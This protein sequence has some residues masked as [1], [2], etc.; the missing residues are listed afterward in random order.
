MKKKYRLNIEMLDS[1]SATE[2][3][4]IIGEIADSQGI[5]WALCGGVAMQI[6]GS[7]R[8]TKDLDFIASGVMPLAPVKHLSFGGHRYQ[9]ET[10]RQIVDADWIV[11]R[12]AWKDLFKAAL[13]DA[14]DI[15][16]VPVV[17]PEW[18]VLLKWAA[19]RP[20]D[21]EDA[22]FLLQ[23]GLVNRRK[24]KANY[25]KVRGH[26]EWT[27]IFTGLSRWL[28]KADNFQRRGDENESYRTEEDYLS[29]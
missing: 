17:S 24:M 26:R 23:S 16:G 15:N 13:A 14:V 18:L 25:V 2:A 20:K 10:S 28:D 22:V 6:Y 12:D 27:A 1:Q 5:D 9:V 7:P 19:G 8:L 11:R 29:R 4:E 3:L 21:E